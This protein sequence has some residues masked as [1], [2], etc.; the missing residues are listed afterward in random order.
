M[1]ALAATNDTIVALLGQ[2]LIKH[3]LCGQDWPESEAIRAELA[4]AHAVFSDLEVA[5]RG[6]NSGPPTREALTLHSA[7]PAVIDCLGQLGVNLLATAN[8][9]AFDL[10][11]GGIADAI[12]ALRARRVAFAG[13]GETLAAASRPALLSAGPHRVALVAAASGR[14]REGGAATDDRPGVAEIR[15]GESGAI[16]DGDLARTLASISAAARTG[17]I[18]IA[19]LHNHHWEEPLWRTPGWQRDY[20]R[21][22]I[23]AGAHLFVAHGTPLLQGIEVWRGR[24]IFHGLSSFIFQ[25]IKEDGFYDALAW[26]SAIAL[27]R[28][29]GGRFASAEI[30]PVQ[31]NATGRGGPDDLETRGRPALAGGGQARIILERL[32]ALSADLGYRF[33]HDG[34]RGRIEV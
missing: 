9:H 18:V 7:D 8:N 28:F 20:A 15:L 27:C 13:T 25:T 21:A 5:I 26:Q 2:S 19:Y 1:P 11:T 34:R 6:P 22:C 30:V 32:T 33:V 16:E 31:L 17:A 29:S 14:I 23:D 3:D 4:R 12:A 10:N 24:P